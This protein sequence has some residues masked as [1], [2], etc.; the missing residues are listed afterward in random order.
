MTSSDICISSEY[1]LERNETSNNL[2]MFSFNSSN[3]NNNNNNNND[4]NNNSNNNNNNNFWQAHY[5]SHTENT[6]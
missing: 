1:N 2:R 4:N 5:G 6:Q 3:N